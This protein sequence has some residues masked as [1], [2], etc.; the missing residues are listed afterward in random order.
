MELWSKNGSI[1]IAYYSV[2]G[3]NQCTREKFLNIYDILNDI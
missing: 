2:W 1:A 3:G